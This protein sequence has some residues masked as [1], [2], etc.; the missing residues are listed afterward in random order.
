MGLLHVR[1]TAR[2]TPPTAGRQSGTLPR[3]TND[4]RPTP[5]PARPRF[6]RRQKIIGVLLLLILWSVL[7]DQ[8]TGKG[9]GSW[10]SYGMVLSH[11]TPD[12]WEGCSDG[13]DGSEYTD[14]YYG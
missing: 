4:T 11:G 1:V 10:P 7:A 3:M 9:C 5:A 14:R 6:S 13:P 2:S 12:H 8:W